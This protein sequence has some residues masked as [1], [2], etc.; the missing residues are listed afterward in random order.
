MTGGD[1]RGQVTP[2]EKKPPASAKPQKHETTFSVIQSPHLSLAV[3]TLLQDQEKEP[4]VTIP[5]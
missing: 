1:Y 3:P 5:A 2:S 4:R